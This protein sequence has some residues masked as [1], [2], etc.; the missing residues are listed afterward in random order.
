MLA[1]GPSHSDRIRRRF[2]RH[3][4]VAD[5]SRDDHLEEIAVADDDVV[6]TAA[7][8]ISALPGEKQQRRID[9]ELF[10]PVGFTQRC[11]PQP[12]SLPGGYF[13]S[14]RN[15]DVPNLRTDIEQHVRQFLITHRLMQSSQR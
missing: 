3:R 12:R 7:I 9:E 13:L 10:V 1:D 11:R 8:D 14:A 2:N 4:Y 15:S 5:F 6:K